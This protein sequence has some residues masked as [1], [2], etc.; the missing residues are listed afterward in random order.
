MNV[1]IRPPVAAVDSVTGAPGNSFCVRGRLHVAEALCACQ[2]DR[3]SAAFSLAVCVGQSQ[4][5]ANTAHF[6][7]LLHTH[8]VMISFFPFNFISLLLDFELTFI[9]LTSNF[10]PLDPFAEHTNHLLY[11][12]DHIYIYKGVCGHCSPSVYTLCEV[13]DPDAFLSSRIKLSQ[14]GWLVCWS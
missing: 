4:T 13:S 10:L 12:L 5:V 6:A 7:S 9:H 11:I 2:L 8:R 3:L 1:W 14:S